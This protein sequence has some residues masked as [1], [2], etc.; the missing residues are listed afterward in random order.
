MERRP[1]RACL[2]G[3]ARLGGRR[4][5]A[6]CLKKGVANIYLTDRSGCIVKRMKGP[7]GD[8]SAGGPSLVHFRA[9]GG[10]LLDVREDRIE[11][12]GFVFCVVEDEAAF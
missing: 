5:E 4:G 10:V 6:V 8:A 3:H 2:L 11:R 12:C 7:T 9:S 1:E